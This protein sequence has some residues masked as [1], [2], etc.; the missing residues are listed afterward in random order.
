MTS[1]IAAVLGLILGGLLIYI[2]DRMPVKWLCDY[3]EEPVKKIFPSGGSRRVYLGLFFAAI[4]SVASFLACQGVEKIGFAF[5]LAPMMLLLLLIAVSDALYMIIPDELVGIFGVFSL[6]FAVL[7]FFYSEYAIHNFLLSPFAGLF[8][9]TLSLFF[10]RFAG[11]VIFKKDVM[12]MGDIKLFAACGVASGFPGIIFVMI[13]TVLI[14]GISFG[15]QLLLKRV[16]PD[17]EKP[18]GPYIVAAT[19]SFLCFNGQILSFIHWYL[20]FFN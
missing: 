3:D 18:L 20:S 6:L 2:F 11:N 17:D 10:L 4:V 14:A 1:I 12:G 9:A 16:A 13:I 15:V 7:D 8:T 5:I 19:A